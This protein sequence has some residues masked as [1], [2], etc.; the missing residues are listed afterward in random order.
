MVNT[1]FKK[2]NIEFDYV[3]V[4]NQDELEDALNSKTKIIYI[5]SPSNPLLSITDI[6][7]IAS[8]AKK[9]NLI[10]I[11]DNTFASP[12]NQNPI[13][14]GIDL[15]IHSATKYLG[16]HSDILAGVVCGSNDLISV[17]KKS[18]LNFGSN[19]SE[20]ISWLLERSIKTLSVRVLQQNNNASKIANFLS[21]HKKINK[22]YYPGLMNHPKH[23]VAKTQ[24]TAGFG[25]MV[26]FEL[27]DSIDSD[28]FVK[29]LKII[30]PTMSLA[31]VEST[32][33]SPAKTSH[34][35]MDP[36]E[37]DKIGITKNLLRF[38]VGIEDADDLIND[39]S[40]ALEING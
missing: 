39:L 4:S 26:S 21:S 11:I 20:Y 3:D 34:R 37:R 31:G 5:E 17:I 15:V 35:K 36:K 10:S 22:V 2:F 13:S 32:I 12:I 1:E 8:F 28:K 38:S 24:M 40:N 14:L 6:K 18:G 7:S 27:N 33:T 19:I 9:N 30:Q 23:D 25:G 29:T 16:G